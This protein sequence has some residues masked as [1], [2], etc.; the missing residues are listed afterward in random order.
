MRLP[1]DLTRAESGRLIKWLE[2]IAESLPPE[3]PK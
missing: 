3:Q 2:L 1:R